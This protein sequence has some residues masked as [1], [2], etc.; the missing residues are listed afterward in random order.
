R[1]G[2]IVSI[3]C[4]NG[5]IFAGRVFIDATYEGDLLAGAG[6]SYRVGRESSAEYGERLAGVV[7]HKWSTR[8][9][10]D[11]DLSPFDENGRLM[12]GVKEIPRG[13]YGAG[14]HKVQAYNYW[15]CLTNHPDNRLPIE[16]PQNY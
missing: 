11:V 9:Q 12:Y 2:R 10:W 15:I 4:E 14:D 5:A 13:E 3:R 6:V 1:G 7:P 8:K 16:R